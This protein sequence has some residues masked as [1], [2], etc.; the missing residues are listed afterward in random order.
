MWWLLACVS[1]LVDSAGPADPGFCATVEEAGVIEVG[2]CPDC[3]AASATVQVRLVTDVGLDPR[4]PEYTTYKDWTLSPANGGVS[5]AGTT[6]GDGRMSAAVGEGGW[7]FASSFV[8]GGRVCT[9]GLELTAE[10]GQALS[11]CALMRCPA[12]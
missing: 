4:A 6:D 9:A 7:S 11:G 3:P 8:R 1:E 2:G 12:E 10:A 5:Q